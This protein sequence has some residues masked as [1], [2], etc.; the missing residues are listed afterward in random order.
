[1]SASSG[2]N[3]VDVLIFSKD[4]PAQLDLLLRSMEEFAGQLY[5]TVTVLLDWS[6][7]CYRKGYEILYA[8]RINGS[9]VQFVIDGDF[10]TDVMTWLSLAEPLISFLV[11][12]DVFYADAPTDVTA[13]LSLR[14]GDYDYPF[15][16]DG[17]IYDREQIWNLLDG[18]W[19]R[20]PTELEAEGWTMR[21]KLPFKS[22]NPC[23]QPC[24]VG[25]PLNRVSE[26]SRMPH[27]GQHEYDLNESYLKGLRLELLQKPS[28]T[29]GAHEN[30][31]VGWR[32]KELVS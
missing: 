2:S 14:G 1:M 8:E 12:D 22:V 32:A 3:A 20:N 6:A 23:E 27:M 19:F 7:D 30:L 26:S 5:A 15:S 16:V 11:D 29:W 31:S 24:L 17:N 25:I 4:R 13:P 18:L 21:D 28:K 10:H 9:G